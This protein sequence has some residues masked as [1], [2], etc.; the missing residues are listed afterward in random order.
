[1]PEKC[2]RWLAR[3]FAVLGAIFVL[4]GLFNYFH[5]G[6]EVDISHFHGMSMA[7][8]KTNAN[9]QVIF[10]IDGE[11]TTKGKGFYVGKKVHI[12]ALV[13][14]KDTAMY[15]YV[16]SMIWRTEI[17]N[18][19]NPSFYRRD[20]SKIIESANFNAAFN[21]AA[22]CNGYANLIDFKDDQQTFEL[23]GDVAF[24]EEGNLAFGIPFGNLLN[25]YNVKLN[26]I[27]IAPSSVGDQIETN[28]LILLLTW[29]AGALGCA[30]LW[31]SFAQR[32]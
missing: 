17:K 7:M 22:A 11:Y 18:S 3:I 1:M 32:L 12:E 29:I 6:Q 23:N 28:R 4:T 14:I 30:T 10:F 21:D 9:A 2:R 15:K 13:W 5:Q 16:R 8:N 25:S 31:V 27:S 20:N 26:S 24:T 19:E